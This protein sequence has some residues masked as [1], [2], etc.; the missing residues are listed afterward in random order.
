M[1]ILGPSPHDDLNRTPYADL[2]GCLDDHV[3]RELQAGNNDAFAVIFRR[4][5]RLVHMTALRI[6]RDAVKRRIS[7]NRYFWRFTA[8]WDNLTCQRD[9]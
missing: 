9:T 1:G 2:L 6:L 4:Y 5:H 8:R 3:M 7:P